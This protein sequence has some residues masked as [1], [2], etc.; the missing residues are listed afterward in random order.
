VVGGIEHHL[1]AL[2][3]GQA[4]RGLDVTV[5]VAS[6]TGS[7]QVGF[8]N[9]VRVVRTQAWV[10]TASTPLAPGLVASLGRIGADLT[11]LHFPYPPG[12]MAHL[13]LGRSRAMVV[14]Y[15]SDIVRQ[16]WLGRLYRP[17]MRRLLGRSDRIIATSDAYLKSSGP[18][19]RVAA[20]CAV[21]P[22]GI[23]PLPFLAAARGRARS[24]RPRASR[25]V[26]LF[27]GK[28]RHYKGL[29]VLIDA[30][31]Q[32]DASLIVV[33]TGP[34]EHEWR[35]LA[36][37]SPA[38]DRIHFVGQ[39]TDDELPGYYASADVVV[40]PSSQRSEA[41]GLVLVEAM[42]T[43][44]PVVS[45]ELGTGT[46]FVNQHGKTGLVVPP[47]DPTALAQ[48]LESLLA[49][50]GWRRW[51]GENGQRRALAHFHVDPMIDRTIEI[52]REALH[53]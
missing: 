16:R 5:L 23:D 33:G 35:A 50:A 2:A 15:H 39:V 8:E 12:E 22:L 51:L 6:A 28:L 19:R 30:M 36:A 32:V 43:G 7:A 48:A 47:G 4:R 13:A 3:E 1:R 40:L 38:A 29:D 37:G 25:H 20:Q 17:L 52:Y 45:T 24:I 10:T 21:V 44:C 14:T 41:F 18:L 42:A 11:H 49:D 34:M 31:A 27:V 9:G 53:G 46:S 26:V